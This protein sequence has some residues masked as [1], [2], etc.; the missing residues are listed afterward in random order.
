MG[1]QI[2]SVDECVFYCSK[3]MYELYT[4]DSTIVCPDQRDIAQLIDDLKN[5]GLDFTTEWNIGNFL[6]FNINR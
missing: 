2:S 4:N 5:V 1:F 3:T 6:G